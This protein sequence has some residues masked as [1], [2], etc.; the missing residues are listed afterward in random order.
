MM[1]TPLPPPYISSKETTSSPYDPPSTTVFPEDLPTFDYSTPSRR[2]SSR[3]RRLLQQRSSSRG[4]YLTLH[5]PHTL[6]N[7]KLISIESATT[8]SSAS[9]VGSSSCESSGSEDNASISTAD[10]DYEGMN[11]NLI[12][13]TSS[14]YEKQPLLSSPSHPFI[15]DLE[16]GT[17]V[18]KPSRS[19]L[20]SSHRGGV[21]CNG[22][23]KKSKRVKFKKDPRCRHRDRLAYDYIGE[24]EKETS[25]L[26]FFLLLLLVFTM[27]C[28]AGVFIAWALGFAGGKAVAQVAGGLHSGIIAAAAAGPGAIPV[29]KVAPVVAGA[30]V[31]QEV[32]GVPKKEGIVKRKLGK[33]WFKDW[34]GSRPS[35]KVSGGVAIAPEKR[36][37]QAAAAPVG[38]HYYKKS[39]EFDPQ[40]FDQDGKKSKREASHDPEHGDDDENKKVK[41]SFDPEHFDEDGKKEKRTFD[42]E[43]F[44]EDGDGKK[45]KRSFDPNNFNPDPPAQ[46]LKKRSAGST[47]YLQGSDL[48]F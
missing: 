10:T 13:Y 6:N 26:T 38:R 41:R 7:C 30:P 44:D 23:S 37:A 35:F 39:P 36:D 29:Q 45:V 17:L 1:E 46:K 27:V 28:G 48:V 8:S 16:A 15:E 24:D 3:L 25:W 43:H 9:S 47:D 42:P 20:K 32:N 40:H 18:I 4:V 34:V 21:G 14:N 31:V 19:S 12:H 11:E 22:K 33:R 5:I 2:Y